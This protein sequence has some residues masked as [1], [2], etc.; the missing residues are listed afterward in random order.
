MRNDKNNRGI[1]SVPYYVVESMMD[2]QCLTIKR[3]WIVC[4]LLII[5]LIGTNALWLWY[6]S[7]F[8]YYEEIEQEIEAEMEDGDFTVIGIGDNYGKS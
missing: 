4:I 2:R 7:Q 8:E 3:L 5:L 6:E 1:D